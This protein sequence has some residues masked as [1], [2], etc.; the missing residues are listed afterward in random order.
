MRLRRKSIA[1]VTVL[2]VGAAIAPP[3]VA[4]RTRVHTT[5]GRGCT[6]F[7]SLVDSPAPL[8]DPFVPDRFTPQDGF[9]PGFIGMVVNTMHCESVLVDGKDFGPAHLSVFWVLV[10][11]PDGSEGDH[12]YEAWRLTDNRKLAAA[13][14]RYGVRLDSAAMT[15][16]TQ[17]PTP[18]GTVTQSSVE[19][20]GGSSYSAGGIEPEA[21]PTSYYTLP[22]TYTLWQMREGGLVKLDVFENFEEPSNVTEVDGYFTAEPGSEFSQMIG[23]AQPTNHALFTDYEFDV[24]ISQVK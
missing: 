22:Y 24:E 3:A 2:A 8:V 19:W 4:K 6:M 1:L 11:S 7:N 23:G 5:G 18:A 9:Y 14:A 21:D 12:F 10:E 15:L 16:E 13:L 20:D 17:P